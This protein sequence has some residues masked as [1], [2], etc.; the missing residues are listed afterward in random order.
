MDIED[1]F[2]NVQINLILFDIPHGKRIG[3]YFSELNHPQGG[4]DF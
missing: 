4:G 1:L 3:V 2:L